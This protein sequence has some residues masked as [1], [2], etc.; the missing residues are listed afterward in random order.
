MLQL[1]FKKAFDSI[2]WNFIWKTLEKFNFGE[3]FINVIKLCYNNIESTL[4]NNLFC[5]YG[6]N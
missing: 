1:D 6:S 5:V 2:E 4:I 3:K